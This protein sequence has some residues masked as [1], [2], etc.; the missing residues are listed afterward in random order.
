L[1]VTRGRP[2]EFDREKA[3]TD[4]MMVFWRK[5]FHATSLRDLSEALGIRM[6]SLYAAFGSKESLYV[7]AIDLYMKA[8]ET[9]LWQKMEGLPARAAIET[10]LRATARELSGSASHP[11]SCMVTST[12]IDEDMPAPVASAIRQARREWLDVI[13]T[14][15]QS[16]VLEGDLPASADV[17][18]LTRFYNA[19]IQSIGIQAHDGASCAQLDGMI[20]IAM[21][22]WPASAIAA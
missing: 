2:R 17:D 11:S 8:S 19:I 20:N 1:I 16:A 9:L 6:P 3:L 22:A 21:A 7:E 13:R 15:L 14:R 12:L 5:G 18:S 10:L 4:A